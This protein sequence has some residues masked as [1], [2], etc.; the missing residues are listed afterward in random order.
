MRFGKISNSVFILCLTAFFQV[1]VAAFAQPSNDL[2][3]SLTGVSNATLKEGKDGTIT[4]SPSI[5]KKKTELKYA[6]RR[7]KAVEAILKSKDAEKRVAETNA[8][9]QTPLHFAIYAGDGP[10]FV[11]VLLEAGA[12]PNAPL[13]GK[14]PLWSAL[15]LDDENSTLVALTLL[16]YGADPNAT[17]P[18]G[19]TALHCAA[20]RGNFWV[21]QRLLESG[22]DPN[23]AWNGKKPRDLAS[24]A[25]VKNLFDKWGKE[26]YPYSPYNEGEPAV[27]RAAARNNYWA[28]KRL[29]ES[30]AD[31]AATY[32]GK[33]AAELTTS[34]R[35]RE[36][37]GAKGKGTVEFSAYRAAHVFLG[38]YDG[39]NRHNSGGHSYG[40]FLYMRKCNMKPKTHAMYENGVQVC[41]VERRSERRTADDPSNPTHTFFPPN[42][43]KGDVMEAL[44]TLALANADRDKI[45]ADYKGVRVV[46][47]L[48]DGVRGARREIITGYPLFSRQPGV[49]GK[50]ERVDHAREN[51]GVER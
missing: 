45:E 12:D 16:D 15:T 18:D 47:I 37:L 39:S 2:F 25:T 42:W 43:T 3:T 13:F 36:L 29:L 51:A 7:F 41:S 50:L 14:S 49:D 8:D 28:V 46:V 27:C 32:R 21:V 33:S 48:R 11:D 44:G 40:A 6:D 31:K 38:E 20:S 22:A 19:E 24:D 5:S 1:G 10:A 23:A 34:A 17:T 26:P 35:V 9:G 30:G 4:F